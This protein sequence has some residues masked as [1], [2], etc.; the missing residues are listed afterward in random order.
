MISRSSPVTFE[1]KAKRLW[2]ARPASSGRPSPYHSSSFSSCCSFKLPIPAALLAFLSPTAAELYHQFLPGW[3]EHVAGLSLAPYITKIAWGQLLAYCGLFFVCV[4]T[5]HSR[6]AICSICWVI[7]GTACVMAIVGIL[8]EASGTNLIYWFRDT[9]YASGR[10]FGPYINRNHFAGYQAMAIILGLGLLLAQPSKT[11]A[12][13]P[14]LWRHHLLHWFGLLSTGRLLLTLAL[15]LMAGAMIL[16][17]S[18]GGVLSFF[19]CLLCL[20][21]LLH[22]HHLQRYSRVVL[23]LSLVAMVGMGIWLGATPLLKRFEQ[24]SANAWAG[25][26]PAFQAAWEIS[27]DFPLF[28]IGYAMP[29][30]WYQHAINPW[31]TSISALR[32]STTIFYSFLPKPVGWVQDCLWAVC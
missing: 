11:V 26:L 25:R 23:I 30:P 9:S 29:F 7:V 3:P 18:R 12:T 27:K 19:L 4:N 5:L 15:S 24:L 17:A 32:T 21:W 28:G 2:R 6:R 20:A 10:F 1:D 14:L 16:S 8:Q 31:M 13:S 22:Q